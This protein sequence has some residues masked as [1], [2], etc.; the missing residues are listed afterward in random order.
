[1]KQFN[2]IRTI[3]IFVF[4]L[5]LTILGGF[6]RFYQITKNPISL[7]IDEVAFGY[8]AF[9]IFKTGRD[10]YGKFLPLSF[11]ST[12]DYKNPV[13][14]YAM[15]P[16]IAVFGLNE[17][18]VRLPT[19]LIATLSI[20][21]LF[22][23]FLEITQS[24][25]ISLVATLFLTISP[26]HIY[27][28]R[29]VSDHLM[30]A[31]L[32]VLGVL[33]FLRMLKKG[34]YFLSIA[35]AIFFILSMYT[36]YAE[37]LFIPLLILLLFFL[38]RTD[39]RIRAKQLVL[40]MIISAMIASPLIFSILFGADRARAQMT[41][42]GNDVEFVRNVAVKPLK[43]IPFLT[44]DNL[45]LV[46]FGAR[47]YLNYFDPGFLFY[48]GLN[49]TKGGSYGLGVLYLF[50]IPF[51]IWGIIAL[52]KKKIQGKGLIIAW[53]LLGLIPASLTNNEQHPGRTFVILPM[54]ML[55]SAIGTVE[56]FKF[57]RSRFNQRLIKLV[58]AS[59]LI[60]VL[61]NLT[62]AFLIY[63]VHFPR[64]RGE[65]FMEGTKETVEYAL[66]NKNKYKEI[67]F[68][69]Y[70]GIEAPYIV[71]IPHMYIL[72]YSQYD[73]AIY[74]K[75]E[76]I[77]PDGS[78]GFDKFTIRRI[79]WREDRFKK[80]TLFVGSPWS[81]PEKD[82]KNGEILRKVYLSGGQAAFLIVSPK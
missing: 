66:A 39:L 45:L 71:S 61:W 80:D 20:P 19:A 4:L 51:L 10:E 49:M 53:I 14:I 52:I 43:N 60:V 36:Y 5:F 34:G 62:Q 15:V 23:L 65:D 74:Q 81:L 58:L 26:W 76:K 18:S 37:R 41:W 69:P 40:F 56:L 77:R 33:C 1:M 17:F 16:S 55:I 11:K 27:Y 25:I 12:G 13:P 47:K 79:D 67:V 32:V 46:V 59:F 9:S 29:Y 48:N 63:S 78:F 35:S 28:S 50:E 22:L 42:F 7:S 73:P 70:R 68:D 30:A 72:F 24:R 21:I 64:Q 75:E 31:T 57:I 44:S 8:N 38:K 3:H 54:L 6:L 82:L 2:Q